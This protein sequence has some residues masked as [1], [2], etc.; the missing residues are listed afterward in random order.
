[1]GGFTNVS[2]KY[3]QKWNFLLAL[4]LGEFYK[5]ENVG[6]AGE[7]ALKTPI[8]LR[9]GYRD[10]GN[11]CTHMSTTVNGTVR[12]ALRRGDPA[13]EP[14]AVYVYCVLKDGK[15]FT[16][17]K[18][19]FSKRTANESKAKARL[20]NWKKKKTEA[21]VE[22][23]PGQLTEA[24]QAEERRRVSEAAGR[25]IKADNKS[26]RVVDVNHLANLVTAHTQKKT[27]QLK[28]GL[29]WVDQISPDWTLS[30]EMRIKPDIREF[31]IVVDRHGVPTMVA[32]HVHELPRH[33][34]ACLV[35]VRE[36]P[37]DKR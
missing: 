8:A 32:R 34:P 5:F 30:H 9:K 37:K 14:D 16:P 27:I 1:M 10:I 36:I 25:Q 19:F 31:F 22:A 28:I 12:F 2:D 13:T 29:E 3:I 21:G 11:G 6:T 7:R 33:D 17:P 20:E 35:P 4:N 15:E 26:G 18:S 24:E 23:L